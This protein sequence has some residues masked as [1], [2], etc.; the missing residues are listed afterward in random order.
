MYV[1]RCAARSGFLYIMKGNRTMLSAIVNAAAVIA[2]GLIGVLAKKGVP[3]RISD[4]VMKAIGLMVVCLGIKGYFDGSNAIIAIL[5]LAVGTLIGELLRLE[6]RL[7]RLGE[8]INEKMSGKGGGRV[9]E[10]FV[11]ATLLFCVGAMAVLG[12]LQS[13]ITGDHTTIFTKSLMDFIA[14]ILL[15]S[16][17]GIGVAFSAAAVLLYQGSIVLLAGLL[18]PIM[19]EAAVAE[20]SAVGSI[21]LLG[22]GLNILGITKLKVMNMVPAIFVAI[23]LAQVM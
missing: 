4:G 6:D 16:T 18:V 21:V 11:A 14:A 13:G 15:A 1:S 3:E 9:G 2:G 8:K 23:A 22:L 10:G 12:S 5:S 19:T 17:F 7:N 20:M